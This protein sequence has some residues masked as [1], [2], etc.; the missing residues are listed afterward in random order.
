MNMPEFIGVIE[1]TVRLSSMNPLDYIDHQE[2]SKALEAA[3]IQTNQLFIDSIIDSEPDLVQRYRERG[4]VSYGAAEKYF[5]FERYQDIIFYAR[6]LRLALIGQKL[7]FK[8]CISAGDLNKGS[9]ADKL[10]I[11]RD[12][13]PS[14]AVEIPSDLAENISEDRLWTIA[15][16][17]GLIT[18][19]RKG[20]LNITEEIE[21]ILKA[22]KSKF[23]AI[24]RE[25]E[26]IFKT[27]KL[28]DI[29]YLLDFYKTADTGESSVVLSTSLE[30]FKGFGIWIDPNLAEDVSTP[31]GLFKNY[32]P[33]RGR[34]RR[35]VFNGFLDC[36][37][38]CR[39]A[40]VLTRLRVED[41]GED[42]ASVP[43]RKSR[44]Q[45]NAADDTDRADLTDAVQIDRPLGGHSAQIDDILELLRRSSKASDENS[46]YYVSLLTTIVRSSHFGALCYLEKL[47]PVEPGSSKMLALG[48]QHFPPIFETLARDHRHRAIIRK[49]PGIEL[50]LGAMIDELLAAQT[51][52]PPS[53]SFPST[54]RIGRDPAAKVWIKTVCE[55]DHVF[56][57]VVR[58][59]E[60][61][62]GVQVMRRIWHVPNDVINEDR[63]V[64]ML[65]VMTHKWLPD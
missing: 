30:N 8:L 21:D 53:S 59:L 25:I 36:P 61:A 52:E 24:C 55:K 31:H 11:V 22:T 19:E 23:A 27:N 17:T 62:F 50:T 4:I 7:P 6:Q 15:V 57:R 28:K 60:A 47:K 18:A 45:N 14:N 29:Y 65:E 58:H 51:S 38:P 2:A 40:D 13:L 41:S 3:L 20:G 26:G 33:T 12:A 16:E 48:W 63:K 54:R 43:R 1:L 49:I 35:L 32:F 34:E 37:F 56:G 39:P 9:L 46:I 5:R 10:R 64:A 44:R 42:D